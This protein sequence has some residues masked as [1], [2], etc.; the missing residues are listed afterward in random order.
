MR[1]WWSSKKVSNWKV[2]H[3]YLSWICVLKTVIIITIE[4]SSRIYKTVLDLFI[5]K[6]IYLKNN[7]RTSSLANNH[8]K[9]IKLSSKSRK[10]NYGS[11]PTPIKITPQS[12][13]LS[14]LKHNYITSLLLLKKSMKIFSEKIAIWKL[15]VDSIP[16]ILWCTIILE[17]MINPLNNF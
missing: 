2:A 8:L 13:N 5:V 6:I 3:F 14:N 10:I 9:K 12:N 4:N 11:T 15:L 1:K 7:Y 16:T 17:L